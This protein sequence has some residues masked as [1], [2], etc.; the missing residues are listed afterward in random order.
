ME[1]ALHKEIKAEARSAFQRPPYWWLPGTLRVVILGQLLAV[2]LV[3][4]VPGLA[5]DLLPLAIIAV[6]AIAGEYFLWD[7]A[8]P[9]LLEAVAA[10]SVAAVSPT[11]SALLGFLIVPGFSAA[12]RLG[13]RWGLGIAALAGATVLVVWALVGPA[14]LPQPVG[15][16][17]AWGVLACIVAAAGAWGR[18]RLQ[19]NGSDTDAYLSATRLLNELA[20]LR[21]Q[22]KQGLDLSTLAEGTLARVG[23]LVAGAPSA[24]LA[25]GRGSAPS[26]VLASRFATDEWLRELQSGESLTDG[27]P[28]RESWTFPLASNRDGRL[29]IETDAPLTPELRHRIDEVVAEDALRLRA[30]ETFSEVWQA[31]THEERMRIARDIH[32]GIAQDLAAIAYAADEALL[33]AGTA[34]ERQRLEPLRDALRLLLG[35]LR[36][37]IFDLRT[38]DHEPALPAAIS[39]LARRTAEVADLELELRISGSVALP[40]EVD[41]ELTRIA[42]EAL[43]NVRRHAHAARLIVDL[44]QDGHQVTLRIADDGR[45][46]DWRPVPLLSSGVAGMRDRARSIGAALTVEA[47]EDG[48]TVVLVTLG[49]PVDDLAKHRSSR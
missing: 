29:V 28:V 25:D 17:V 48:G 37:S 23:A 20:A 9:C 3:V 15:S 46:F 47:G 43:A 32:D 14:P 45:G 41:R 5:V 34:E 27:F 12:L 13:L 19:R 30:A 26:H 42:Q 33:D 11:P 24:V 10:A 7:R 35:E 8:T 22:L 31:A 40:R 16:V 39:D 36:V 2:T 4:Q 44:A 18:I 6:V 21:P 38:E 49:G 1:A